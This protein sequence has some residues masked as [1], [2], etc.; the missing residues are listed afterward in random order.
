MPQKGE[1]ELDI[2]SVDSVIDRLIKEVRYYKSRLEEV[3]VILSRTADDADRLTL[4]GALKNL[5]K[6]NKELK[7]ENQALNKELDTLIRKSK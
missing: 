6:E 7:A 4:L 3:K 1:K 2:S 5:A